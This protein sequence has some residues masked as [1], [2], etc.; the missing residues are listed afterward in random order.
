MTKMVPGPMSTSKGNSFQDT[1]FREGLGKTH[2]AFR[3]L[4][5]DPI[6]DRMLKSET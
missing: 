4:R 6:L 5:D 3:A 2:E 1:V